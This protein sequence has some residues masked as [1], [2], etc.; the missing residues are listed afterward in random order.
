MATPARGRGR[1]NAPSRRRM[2]EATDLDA[3][4]IP[5]PPD[6]FSVEA[7]ETW[8]RLWAASSGWLHPS[9]DFDLLRMICEALEEHEALVL[10]TSTEEGRWTRAESGRLFPHPAVSSCAGSRPS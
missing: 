6:G 1:G 3:A 8:R 4:E 7:T 2:A 5:D 9:A 10:V